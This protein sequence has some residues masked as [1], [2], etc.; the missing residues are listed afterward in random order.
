[1]KLTKPNRRKNN[2]KFYSIIIVTLLISGIIVVG[3]L[4]IAPLNKNDDSINMSPSTNEQIRAGNAI[5]DRFADPDVDNIKKDGSEKPTG[6]D[7]PDGSQVSIAS[8][9]QDDAIGKIVIKTK[10]VGSS[11][12]SCSLTLTHPSGGRILKSAGTIYQPDHTICEG[13]AIDRTEFDVTGQWKVE[14]VATKI[15]GDTSNASTSIT[16][17]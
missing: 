1:M 9:L 16:I 13:F 3:V 14:L 2:L 17:H 8:V 11:W 15:N 5:K 12:K 4:Q 10:L 7:T 6:T